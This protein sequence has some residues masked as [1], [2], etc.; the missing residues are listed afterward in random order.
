MRASLPERNTSGR[1][2]NINAIGRQQATNRGSNPD[3]YGS[4]L[5]TP[6]LRQQKGHSSMP[7]VRRWWI[8]SGVF[9]LQAIAQDGTEPMR[10]HG[11]RTVRCCRWLPAAPAFQAKVSSCLTCHHATVKADTK[12]N[13]WLFVPITPTEICFRASL[14]RWLC[15]LLISVVNVFIGA[16]C[17]LVLCQ[18]CP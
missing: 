10:H 9:P 17:P 4:G 1:T 7:G 16:I 2:N 12:K 3:P 13:V 6:V 11:T 18:H 15:H 14:L 8:L 5:L